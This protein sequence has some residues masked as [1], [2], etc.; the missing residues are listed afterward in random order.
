M[1][2]SQALATIGQAFTANGLETVRGGDRVL[3]IFLTD[4]ALGAL[5]NLIS[6]LQ[7]TKQNRTHLR[8]VTPG[9]ADR[10][11][12]LVVLCCISFV[13]AQSQ[14]NSRPLVRLIPGHS[15][16]SA[17]AETDRGRLRNCCNDPPARQM[18]RDVE[19]QD[20]ALPRRPLLTAD[21]MGR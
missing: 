7:P 11:Y 5:P 21:N 9:N 8:S 17:P 1:Q 10:G 12:R 20:D 16:T 2:L 19:L 3:G 13:P 14:T 6:V 15:K 4:A 18:P